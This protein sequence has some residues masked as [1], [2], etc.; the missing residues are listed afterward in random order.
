MSFKIYQISQINVVQNLSNKSHKCRSG[1][2]GSWSKSAHVRGPQPR[3]AGHQTLQSFVQLAVF[4]YKNN[5][6]PKKYLPNNLV[7]IRSLGS[8]TRHFCALWFRWTPG[9][10]EFIDRG[11]S[12]PISKS[13]CH[14]IRWCNSTSLGRVGI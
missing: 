4:L 3:I 14:K 13:D 6:Q 12:L 10:K 5:Q 9:Y 1:R 8:G 2:E 11:G 7:H